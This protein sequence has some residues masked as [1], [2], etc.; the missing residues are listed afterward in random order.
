[1]QG[2][3]KKIHV[4]FE[5]YDLGHHLELKVHFLVL[6]QFRDIQVCLFFVLNRL[7]FVLVTEKDLSSPNLPVPGEKSCGLVLLQ[8]AYLLEKLKS[9]RFPNTNK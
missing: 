8:Q 5:S 9:K 2:Q 4:L 3:F 1:M 6:L 7:G